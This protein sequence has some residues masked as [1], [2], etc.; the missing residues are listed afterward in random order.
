M[1]TVEGARI[2]AISRYASAPIEYESRTRW[3]RNLKVIEL[4]E[5]KF[6]SHSIWYH[7]FAYQW[8]DVSDV[9]LA[10]TTKFRSEP[11]RNVPVR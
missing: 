9:K 5:Y 3:D 11:W 1:R 2:Q 10:Y 4:G 8:R 7:H 6:P